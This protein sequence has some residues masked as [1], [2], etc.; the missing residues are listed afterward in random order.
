MANAVTTAASAGTAYTR[1]NLRGLGWNELLAHGPPA[2]WS[3]VALTRDGATEPVIARVRDA[4]N[5]RAT[6]TL[7]ERADHLALLWFVAE[8]EGVPGKL[9]RAVVTKERLME[10]E[11]YREI[12]A[13]GEA[14]G[15]AQGEAE[16]KAAAVLAVLGARGIAVSATLRERILR[17]AEVATLNV[18]IRRAAVAS[19]AAVVRAKAPAAGGSTR[20]AQKT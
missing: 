11:L 18:W 14:R 7:A 3:L 16:G 13:E 5:A 6:W 4:I 17:C 9:M 20:Q 12:V 2:L 8:A 15:K 10:S 19:T 1:V